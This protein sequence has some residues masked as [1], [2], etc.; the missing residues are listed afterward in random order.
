MNSSP[1]PYLTA[2]SILS[3]FCISVFHVLHSAQIA[4]AR[5][6]S[7]LAELAGVGGLSD[8]S[9]DHDLGAAG[10]PA[11]SCVSRAE[12]ARITASNSAFGGQRKGESPQA[13]HNGELV[14]RIIVVSAG[15]I[16]AEIF[17]RR[18][19]LDLAEL[20]AA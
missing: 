9:D 14:E 7:R 1:R 12:T 16:A 15:V 10:D 11:A 8:H 6:A 13:L 17:F 2:A 19:H 5:R 20:T 3:G 4:R 18:D